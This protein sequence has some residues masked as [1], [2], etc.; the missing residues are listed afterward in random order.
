VTGQWF[1]TKLGTTTRYRIDYSSMLKYKINNNEK[2]FMTRRLPAN[3]IANQTESCRFRFSFHRT[4]KRS[5]DAQRTM[6]HDSTVVDDVPSVYLSCFGHRITFIE[7]DQLE[8]WTIGATK[9]VRVIVRR[10]LCYR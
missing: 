7:N 5:L 3:I 1:E 8:R 4:T 6:S 9:H 2:E 10:C